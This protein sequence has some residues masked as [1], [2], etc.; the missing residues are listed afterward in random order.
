MAGPHIDDKDQAPA[1]E[2]DAAPTAGA[3]KAP[4]AAKRGRG[5][6][7]TLFS[8]ILLLLVVLGLAGYGAIMFKDKDERIRLVADYVETGLAEGQAALDKAQAGLAELTDGAKPQTGA[9]KVTTHRVAPVAQA[10]E[11]APPRAEKA[12]EPAPAPAVAAEPPRPAPP[13]TDVSALEARLAAAEELARKALQAAEAA[14]QAAADAA[15]IGSEAAKSVRAE[16]GKTETGK[17]EATESAPADSGEL[18]AKDLVA[19]LEGRLDVLGDQLKAMQDRL[20]APKNETRV[21]P[22]AGEASK[23]VADGPAAMVVVAFALQR[24]LDAG[25]P[26]AEEIAALNRL[27]GE[28]APVAV[29]ADMAEKGAPTAEQLHEAFQPVAKKLRALDASHGDFTE[30]L[31]QGASKLVRVR[32]AGKPAHTEKLAEP[33][34]LDGRLDRIDAALAHGDFATA[35]AAFQTLPDAAKDAAREFGETL[36][37]RNEAAKAADALLHGAIAALG[38]AKK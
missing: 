30:H 21:E 31:L 24:E 38:G 26:Y 7:S 17:T 3:S 18:T 19:A 12:P 22:D 8:A 29:L 5:L 10:P 11:P 15:Q 6:F 36:R 25:R 28:A 23:T 16:A 9:A 27:G 32:P 4:V 14:Q 34:T 35:D 33:D 1:V 37:A 20:D 13:A 2:G